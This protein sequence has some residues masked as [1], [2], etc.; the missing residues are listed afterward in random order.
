VGAVARAAAGGLPYPTTGDIEADL[1]A[2]AEFVSKVLSGPHFAAIF[3]EIVGSVLA[4]P[5]RISFDALAPNRATLA[6]LYR[7][8][9][10]EEGFDSDRDPT[11]GFDLIFGATIAHLLATGTPPSEAY[12]R[13]AGEVV[14]EGL[15]RRR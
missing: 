11:L 12:A 10:A 14:V 7:Q 6:E 1:R 8:G 3:P 2:G 9:A 13:Q 15:R 5:S 4:R